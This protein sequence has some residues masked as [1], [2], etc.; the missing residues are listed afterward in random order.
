MQ[1]QEFEIGNPDM[2][3]ASKTNATPIGGNGG[4]NGTSDE[5]NLEAPYSPLFVPEDSPLAPVTNTDE[6]TQHDRGKNAGIAIVVPPVE[7]RWE[8]QTYNEA[9]VV[10]VLEEHDDGEDLQYLV[11]LQ[12]GCKQK[13]SEVLPDHDTMSRPRIILPYPTVS[14]H[15]YL[16]LSLWQKHVILSFG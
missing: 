12:D 7:R 8:Y 5:E 14:L 11:K 13:V 9:P 3:I 10:K 6:A 4:Q 1:E 16:T 2:P 15:R